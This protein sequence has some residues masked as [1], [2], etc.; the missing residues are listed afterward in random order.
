[1]EDAIQTTGIL[2][3]P[4]MSGNACKHV[5]SAINH[6]YCQP[7]GGRNPKVRTIKKSQSISQFDGLRAVSCTI[8]KFAC[9]A[10]LSGRSNIG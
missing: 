4:L 8:W 1:M 2:G 5:A 7:L 3:G 9:A 10:V 6:E